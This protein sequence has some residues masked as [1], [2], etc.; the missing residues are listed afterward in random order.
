MER[1]FTSTVYI[2]NKEKVLLIFH[3]KLKK[4]LAA[5]GHM[6]ANETPVETARREVKEETGLEIDFIKQENLWVDRWNAKSF[7]RPYLCLVEEIPAHGSQA[8]HQHIDF[9]YLATPAK[10]QTTI[11][12]REKDIEMRWFTLEEIESLKPD[13]EIFVETQETIRAF[14]NG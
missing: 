11:H 6:E 5:G 12:E 9:I 1:Q 3:N 2:V 14:L 8:A 10:N 13:D 4:W 7:E